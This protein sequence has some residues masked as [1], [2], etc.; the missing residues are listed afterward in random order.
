[1]AKEQKDGVFIDPQVRNLFGKGLYNQERDR[2]I[3]G[4]QPFPSPGFCQEFM[5]RL[6]EG[7]RLSKEYHEYLCDSVDYDAWGYALFGYLEDAEQQVGDMNLWDWVHF[8]E[9]VKN[10]KLADA[11]ESITEI[12]E[13]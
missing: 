13:E 10:K 11:I 4:T 9:A 8:Y 3:E 12:L 5:D 6:D 1:M 2:L 7:L